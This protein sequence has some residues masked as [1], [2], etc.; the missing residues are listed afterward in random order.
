M[1]A[2]SV[3]SK[4]NHAR[5]VVLVL[6]LAHVAAR[7][8]AAGPGADPGAGAIPG[9][10]PGARL[11]A[12]P[13]ASLGARALPRGGTSPSPSQNP[14]A[15]AAPDLGLWIN[16]INNCFDKLPRNKTDLVF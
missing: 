3:W 7:D 8:L 9:A 16:R 10:G 1:V 5:G 11:A 6:I 13:G 12:S 4:T 15:E 14:P 2:T